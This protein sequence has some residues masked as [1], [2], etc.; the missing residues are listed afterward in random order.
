MKQPSAS[1]LDLLR[2][3][4]LE[5]EKPASQLTWARENPARAWTVRTH[6]SIEKGVV[7]VDLH[8]LGRKLA[9]RIVQI[10][11]NQGADLRTGAVRFVTGR[12]R[13]SVTGPVLR[14]VVADA[15]VKACKRNGWGMHAEG[16]ARFILI[17]DPEKAPAS[18]TG[19]QTWPYWTAGL[20]FVA[21]CFFL[22]P[23]MGAGLSVLALLG[24]LASR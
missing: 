13:H 7:T 10:C 14:E 4:L 3:R 6:T 23:P 17:I 8:D 18:A 16:G 2:D 5:I 20:G 1:D 11:E 19:N 24:F 12:G 21:L 22:S 9:Q 15:L